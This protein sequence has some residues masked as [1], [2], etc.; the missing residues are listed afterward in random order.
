M[1]K[2]LILGG[3]GMLGHKLVQQWSKQF[4]VWTTL[5]GSFGSVERFGIF[6]REKTVARV[7]AENFDSIIQVFDQVKPEIVVNCIGVIK[8]LP[9]S[10][11]P[12]LTLSVN[13]IFPH[14]LS[15]LCQVAGAR[16]ITLS[17]DCVFSGAR[18]HY[19]EQ[20][21]PDAVDLYGQSKHWG[22]I[23][24]DNCLTVRTS[25][26]GRELGSAHSLVEWFLSNRKQNK[27]VKGFT[28][29]IYTG[30]P[31]VV[32][33]DLLA[34][35]IESHPNLSGVWHVSSDSINKFELLRLINR[36]FGAN[37]QIEPDAN[38]C[39]D[40]SLDSARFR[41]LTNFK[42]KTWAEMIELMANDPTPYE[43]FCNKR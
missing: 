39:C 3:A 25:I 40:R 6:N 2:V 26:I 36:E 13:S 23:A 42:P 14:R 35:I 30:F 10:K 27:S 20:D 16:L 19:T 5:R 12:I 18:G 22:E 17:T 37:L 31:T 43:E 32:F 41:A 4:N 29:A 15:Q 8:Q 9:N 11:N 34:D 33:A 7:S 38:F 28:K 24:A 1:K 21:V